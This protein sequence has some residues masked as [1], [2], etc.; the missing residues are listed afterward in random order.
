MGSAAE[1]REK[2]KRNGYFLHTC[3]SNIGEKS[4]STKSTVYKEDQKVQR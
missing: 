1:L 4:F 2:K 3:H